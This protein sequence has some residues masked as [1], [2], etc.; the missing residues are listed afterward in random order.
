[1]EA[2]FL[3]LVNMSITASW[4]VLAVVILRFLL[5]KAPKAIHCTLWAMVA[6]RLMLPFSL[7]SIFSLVPSTQP[8]PEEFLYA[9]TPQ[10]QTSFVSVDQTLNPVIAE[11]MM[12]M[13]SAS[14]NPTQIYA[15]VFSQIWLLG[16]VLMLLYLLI[17]YYVLRKKVSA[18]IRLGS[19]VW[20]CDHISSPFIL[21]VLCPGIYLPSD[22][23]PETADLVL[24]HERAHLRRKDHWWKPL[25]FVLLSIYWFNPVMW[26]AYILLCRDIEQACDEKVVKDLDPAGRKA[27]SMALLRCSVPRLMIAACPLAFGEVGVKKRIRSVLSYKRPAFW[28]VLLA[29]IAGIVV[30]VCFLTDPV[31]ETD[32]WEILCRDVLKDIQRANSYHITVTGQYEGVSFLNDTSTSQYYK[33]GDTLMKVCHIPAD[34]STTGYLRENGYFYESIT[35]D[36]SMAWEE[37][38]DLAEDVLIPWL[39]RFQYDGSR[40]DAVARTETE[41][42]Y[43]IRLNVYEPAG[44]EPVSD[45]YHV[46]FYFDHEDRFLY[47][48]QTVQGEFSDSPGHPHT[49]TM[50]MAVTD[51]TEEAVRSSLV[52]LAQTDSRLAVGT[53]VPISY[54]TETERE[55]NSLELV[56]TYAYEVTEDSFIVHDLKSGVSAR[57]PVAWCWRGYAEADK[58]IPLMTVHRLTQ[59]FGILKPLLDNAALK[60]QYISENYH[61]LSQDGTLCLAIAEKSADSE[62]VNWRVHALVNDHPS[63]LPPKSAVECLSR[64][65]EMNYGEAFNRSGDCRPGNFGM[66]EEEIST[67]RTIISQMPEEAVTPGGALGERYIGVGGGKR[68]DHAINFNFYFYYDY[69]SITLHWYNPYTEKTEYEQIDYAPLEA[70]LKSMMQPERIDN[71][72]VIVSTDSNPNEDDSFQYVSY[73]HEEITI[74]LLKIVGWEY[75]IVPYVDVHTDFGIRCKPEWLEDWLFF[76]YTRGELTQKGTSLHEVDVPDSMVGNDWHYLFE[77]PIDGSVSWREWPESWKMIYRY[78]D[79]GAYYIYNEGA[80]DERLAEHDRGGYYHI[81]KSFALGCLDYEAVIRKASIYVNSAE[82]EKPEVSYEPAANRWHVLWHKKDSDA[83]VSVTLDPVWG[84]FRA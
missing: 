78:A 72:A 20:L 34:G 42:S 25:G 76:G 57:Y 63:L 22:L 12:P 35:Y 33:S 75:E 24:K 26:L 7:E 19:G 30:A 79:G 28:I 60:Y 1:M 41:D 71:Y 38:G 58:M 56:Q 52:Q 84:G 5:K 59:P 44:D 55:H 80:F 48:V 36:G 13:E 51:A 68:S 50:T 67:F 31:T 74:A 54:E 6:I 29:V 66:T 11:S 10:L 70:F 9:A 45:S 39:V 37:T 14:A 23:D 4:L 53:Y 82:Y 8:L 62:L 47:A 69:E 16:L 17:S 40:V 65:D 83:V 32:E 43:Y 73:S 27:Y 81:E 2:F 21:G 3:K 64:I 15:F 61:L 49:L 46:D 18:S 77:T